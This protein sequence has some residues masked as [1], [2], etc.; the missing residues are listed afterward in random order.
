MKQ[1]FKPHEILTKK[2]PAD[3]GMVYTSVQRVEVGAE[4]VALESGAEEL[5][6]I[7]IGGRVD[8]QTE[9][10]SGTA[11][12]MDMLYLPIESGITFTS[13]E[14]GVMM[15]YGAP[16]TRRTKFGHIRFADVDKDSRHKVYG[17]VENG[18]RRDVW[19]Y[20]DESFDSSRFL[21]G[22]CHGA[23][24]GW[25]AWPPHEHGREREETYVYFGMAMALPHSS[26][27]MIWTSPSWQHWCGMVT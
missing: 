20:I 6:F 17:K 11:V 5:C 23:D 3:L 1:Y 26:C 12:Q 13:S 15:R 27:T 9:G 25:T 2:E 19:N 7:C 21:T 4:P 22:I 14:G 10:Q 8:Y 24:G 16:C 18:T